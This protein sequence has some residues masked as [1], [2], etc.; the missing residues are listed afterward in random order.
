MN[1]P[2]QFFN[3]S[4]LFQIRVLFNAQWTILQLHHDKNKLLFDEMMSVLYSRPKNLVELL[5]FREQLSSPLVFGGSVFLIFLV[6]CVVILLFVFVRCLVLPV[7]LHC[8]FL[9]APSGF[10]DVY[11]YCA[12]S[13]KQQ[14]T[15]RQSSFPEHF[16]PT[17]QLFFA[18]TPRCCM[19]GG[20]AFNANLYSLVWPTRNQTNNLQHSRRVYHYI[21]K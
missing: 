9:I 20:E 3:M 19:L 10:F 14:S 4:Q 2:P 5:T 12:S 8:S 1:F 11:F 18:L 21:T 7:T 16:I 17:S 6:F 13:L 15:Y